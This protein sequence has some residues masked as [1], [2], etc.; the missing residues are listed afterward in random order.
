MVQVGWTT[1]WAAWDFVGR[2]PDP[3]VKRSYRPTYRGSKTSYFG[4][5]N[6]STKI[7][8]SG[9]EI[10]CNVWLMLEPEPNGDSDG[11]GTPFLQIQNASGFH[12][13]D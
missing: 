7:S 13:S 8:G 1:G 2:A 5:T 12:P 9:T 6:S 3:V 4:V 11:K 10:L